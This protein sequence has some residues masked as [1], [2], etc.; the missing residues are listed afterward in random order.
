MAGGTSLLRYANVERNEIMQAAPMQMYNDSKV[1]DTRTVRYHRR[2][3]V[4]VVVTVRYV[5]TVLM[6][7][8]PTYL[9]YRTFDGMVWRRRLRFRKVMAGAPHLRSVVLAAQLIA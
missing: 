7:D 9:T 6:C 4:A 3:V 8:R 2:R 1:F 5:C